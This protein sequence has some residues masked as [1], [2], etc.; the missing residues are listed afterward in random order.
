MYSLLCFTLTGNCV[1]RQLLEEEDWGG[2]QGVPQV[3]D[4]SQ[5]EG[6]VDYFWSILRC[7]DLLITQNKYNII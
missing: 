1:G 3:E 5:E 4:L 7:R 6:E 2:D